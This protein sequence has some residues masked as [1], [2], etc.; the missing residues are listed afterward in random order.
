MRRHGVLPGPTPAPIM[1]RRL[2]GRAPSGSA[3]A[4]AARHAPLGRRIP[5]VGRGV[6]DR[7]TVARTHRVGGARRPPRDGDGTAAD[8]GCPRW[9]IRCSSTSTPPTPDPSCSRTCRRSPRSPWAARER[10]DA[11]E[12]PAAGPVGSSVSP[13][14]APGPY[15]GCCSLS[16]GKRRWSVIRPRR[17]RPVCRITSRG[18][19]EAA[20]RLRGQR[21]SPHR[22]VRRRGASDMTDAQRPPVPAGNPLQRVQA[23]TS[24]AAQC[25]QAGRAG[26]ATARSRKTDGAGKRAQLGRAAGTGAARVQDA[27]RRRRPAASSRTSS[28]LQKAKRTWL[29][30]ASGSS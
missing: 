26:R 7:G 5:P 17:R 4:A 6:D 10:A 27:R 3:R 12:E 25:P 21:L 20:L 13:S 28:L 24:G 19:R 23:P 1:E 15:D 9:P 16:A 22:R 8:G 18:E 30:P 29:R 14:S 2:T 11:C